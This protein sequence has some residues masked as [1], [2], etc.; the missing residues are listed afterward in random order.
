[1]WHCDAPDHA[2]WTDSP[3]RLC[4]KL[5]WGVFVYDG[6]SFCPEKPTSGTYSPLCPNWNFLFKFQ[7][8]QSA[9]KARFL[10]PLLFVKCRP[11]KANGR[12]CSQS[13]SSHSVPF[14]TWHAMPFI[15]PAYCLLV[16]NNG[17]L[18]PNYRLP[19]PNYRLPAPNETN[20]SRRIFRRET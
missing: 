20:L 2:F 14:S 10:F 6:L 12:L 4:I 13:S 9:G 5:T 7:K 19:A 15:R 3:S 1:M 16:A 11:T 18:R 8:W 17:L